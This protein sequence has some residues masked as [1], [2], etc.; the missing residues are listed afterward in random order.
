LRLCL[1]AEPRSRLSELFRFPSFIFSFLAAFPS[2]SIVPLSWADFFLC[3]ALGSACR[4]FF[5][6][7]FSAPFCIFWW[8]SPA[9]RNYTSFYLVTRATEIA[10]VLVLFLLPLRA[11][12]FC[13]TEFLPGLSFIFFPTIRA[14]MFFQWRKIFSNGSRRT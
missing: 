10:I 4:G 2:P 13:P 8:R 5:R 9:V 6:F 11:C 14:R 1:T 3:H 12:A 7:A